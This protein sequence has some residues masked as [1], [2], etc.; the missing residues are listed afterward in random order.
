M[1]QIGDME[2]SVLNTSKQIVIACA[3]LGT[4]MQE[5]NTDIHKGLLPFENKPILWHLVFSLPIHCE[6]IILLG[7]KGDLIR[8]FLLLSFPEKRFQ[9]IEVLDYS[10]SDSG[11]AISLL[12]AEPYVISDFWYVPCD[13]IFLEGLSKILENSPME[14]TIYVAP[15]KSVTTPSEYTIINI[16]DGAA[17]SIYFKP[18]E[19]EDYDSCTVFT[20]LMYIK[21]SN[22]FFKR[23]KVFE[24]REFVTSLPRGILCRQVYDWIDLGSPKEFIRN[25]SKSSKFDF[26]KPHEFTYIL[27][28]RII[29]YFADSEEASKKLIKPSMIPNAYPSEV[30]HKGQFL[31]YRKVGGVTLY[32]VIN[33]DIFL[34]LL[35]WLSETLWMQSS[36]SIQGDLEAFY[37]G[38]TKNRID[39]I[40]QKLPYDFESNYNLFG[41]VQI[42]PRSILNKID[43]N[44]IRQHSVTVNI[45]GDLQ[46]DNILIES[47]GSFRLIDWRTTFG[48]Q[49]LLGDLYYDLAKLLG[50]IHMNYL[51][52]KEGDFDFSFSDGLI[53]YSIPSVA[54]PSVLENLLFDFAKAHYLNIDKINYLVAIIYLNMAPMHNRPFSDLL[55]FHAMK[56]LSLYENEN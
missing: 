31:S 18:K 16:E 49:N 32:H 37:I 36:E 54:E 26:S 11:T 2:E 38:K 33:P 46:F 8:D 20:G 34:H 6:I 17:E 4:R 56:L 43:W 23:L 15:L 39:Q 25:T 9:F 29:K 14:D 24:N 50:G 48:S 30:K 55:F 5:I 51:K 47:D 3:G 52:I 35:E 41:K 42:T 10:S 1:I 53:E 40:N 12:F 27:P 45:H 21:D 44:V 13:G 28:E 22:D 7:H 19:I